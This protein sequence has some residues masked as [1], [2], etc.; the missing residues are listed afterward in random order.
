MVKVIREAELSPDFSRRRGKFK[1]SR[2]LLSSATPVLVE[3]MKNFLV[4][5]AEMHF[6]GDL[7]EYVA[8]SELFD[9]IKESYDAPEYDFTIVK[10][11]DG[12][13]KITPIRLDPDGQTKGLR[14]LRKMDG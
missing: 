14:L 4:V 12:T 1:V 6:N 13:I 3:F 10:R 8:I 5:R 2:E 9:P 7:I 11:V